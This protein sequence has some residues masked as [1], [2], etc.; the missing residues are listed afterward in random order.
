M[1]D[2]TR[3]G[4]YPPVAFIPAPPSWYYHPDSVTALSTASAAGSSSH[5]Y[6][7]GCGQGLYGCRYQRHTS[8]RTNSQKI[9][10]GSWRCTPC[11]PAVVEFVDQ[12]LK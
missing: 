6:D 7:L 2:G 9:L 4:D 11:V 5:I 3:F 10:E 12:V 1:L 8:V